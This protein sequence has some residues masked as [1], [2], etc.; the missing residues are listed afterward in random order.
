MAALDVRF[1]QVFQ[2]SV[3][4]TIAAKHFANRATIRANAVDTEK[5]E[6]VEDNGIRWFLT[7]H[8]A[9]GVSHQGV[10]TCRYELLGN[11][12]RWWTDGAGNMLSEGTATFFPS[13]HGTSMRYEHRLT[14]EL[15]IGRLALIALTPI[16]TPIARRGISKYVEKMISSLHS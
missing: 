5:T 12:V 16:A 10:Y 9:L 7:R 11:R 15:P 6:E 3:T 1:D 14:I 4:P 2:L 13:Q 8:E